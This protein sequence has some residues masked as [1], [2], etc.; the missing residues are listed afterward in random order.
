MVSNFGR[1]YNDFPVKF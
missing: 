1:F